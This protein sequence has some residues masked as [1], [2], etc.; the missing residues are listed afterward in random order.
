MWSPQVLLI[1]LLAALCAG[2][3]VWLLWEV[4]YKLRHKA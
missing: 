4:V 1:S 2:G 3:L